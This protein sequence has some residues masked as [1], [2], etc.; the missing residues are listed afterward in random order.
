VRVQS[1]EELAWLVDELVRSH[2]CHT[3]I[4]YGS[5]ARG[6][7]TPSSDY[8]VAGLR[9][10][11]EPARDAR[12]VGGRYLDA[13][14]YPDTRSA[15]PDE[16]L[17]HLRGGRVLLERDG[18]GSRLLGG[19]ELV[20][21]RGPKP[22]APGEAELR[23]TWARKMLERIARD[24]LEARYRRTWL[25]FELLEY[26]F[27]LRG[28][29]YLGPKQSFAWLAEHEPSAHAAFSAALEPGAP[30]AEIAALVELVIG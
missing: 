15:A 5:R 25:L 23:R 7:A 27:A 28:R 18:H 21:A 17:L 19:L 8:D 12:L 22:L 30:L 4:L 11:G 26:H 13:F 2:G 9:E 6:D 24:D 29:W 1:D 20:F 14:I 10:G 3:V 16:A